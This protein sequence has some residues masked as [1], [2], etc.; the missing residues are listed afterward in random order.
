MLFRSG[1]GA[2]YLLL[3]FMTV[4][5]F[6]NR[7]N[8][9]AKVT[10]SIY[11][12]IL[13]T[14]IGGILQLFFFGLLI[15]WSFAG[16]GI[17]IAYIF[18][19]TVSSSRDF[20]T[21]LYTRGITNDYIEVL[22]QKDKSFGFIIID[23]DNFK[24]INDTFGHKTGDKVLIHFAKVLDLTFNKNAIVSRFGGDEFVIIIKGA[25]IERLREFHSALKSNL[26]N[27]TEYDLVTKTSFSYGYVIREEKTFINID[28][29][30][31][32]S[33][34]MMYQEKADHKNL[35]RRQSDK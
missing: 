16:L 32:I 7:N 30:L 23:I 22:I 28:E 3:I 26:V 27:Y 5:T 17:I 6:R 2:V 19:E 25:T 10:Y 14:S 21:K 12:M 13:L 31:D 35:K 1:F 4:Q 8:L 11:T 33:D 18:T 29:L 24:Y 9:D 15:M 20:L 34:K